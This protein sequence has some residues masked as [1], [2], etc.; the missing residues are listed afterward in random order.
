MIGHEGKIRSI[1]ECCYTLP[2]AFPQFREIYSVINTS[3]SP[4]GKISF[5]PMTFTSC[6]LKLSLFIVYNFCNIL[7]YFL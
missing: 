2:I 6:Q 5:F 7:S 3:F 4:R 1:V